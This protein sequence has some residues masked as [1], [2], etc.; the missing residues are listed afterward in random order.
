MVTLKN[1]K[2]FLEISFFLVIFFSILSSYIV[3][4]QMGINLLTNFNAESNTLTGWQ[5]CTAGSTV[6]AM[7]GCGTAA[8][9]LSS[10]CTTGGWIVLNTCARTGTYGFSNQCAYASTAVYVN[11][12]Q[13]ISNLIVGARYRI[14][15]WAKLVGGGG[16]LF[17]AGV[18]STAFLTSF[19]LPTAF[20]QYSYNFTATTTSFTFYLD[21]NGGTSSCKISIM[22]LILLPN[23]LTYAR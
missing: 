9:P 23:I 15:F 21:G 14:S 20:T 17:N 18:N 11:L 6:T 12:Q 22:F 10:S 8:A 1:S 5:I 4:P 19:S 16:K 2:N 13:T 3:V 7:V